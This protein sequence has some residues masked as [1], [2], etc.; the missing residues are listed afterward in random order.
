[1]M[2]F[3]ARFLILSKIIKDVADLDDNELY[4]DTDDVSAYMKR[5]VKDVD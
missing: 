2:E 4:I 5:N 1:M 3:V